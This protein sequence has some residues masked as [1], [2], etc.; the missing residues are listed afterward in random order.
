MN[1]VYKNG[2]AIGYM[3][4]DVFVRFVSPVPIR[5]LENS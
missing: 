3:C 2:F 4:G 1:Y 5:N